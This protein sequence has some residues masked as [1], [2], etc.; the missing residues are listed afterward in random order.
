MGA[1]V[2]VRWMALDVGVWD[3]NTVHLTTEQDG[4]YGKLIRHYWR[5][6]P[7]PDD[8]ESLAAIAK[9]PL[10][11]W[12]KMRPKVA[13]YFFSQDGYLRHA[14]LEA[15]HD[16]AVRM[17]TASSSNGK[18]GGRPKKGEPKRKQRTHRPK[19]E[20]LNGGSVANV[21]EFRR[22]AEQAAEAA[23]DALASM[24]T[25]P[26]VASIATLRALMTGDNPCDWSE[27]ILPA[28]ASA[29]AWHREKGGPGS[30]TSWRTAA[31]IAVQ[32]RD[33]RLAG[34]TKTGTL[35]NGS[36]KSSDRDANYARAFG[37]DG[38]RPKLHG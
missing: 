33:Q 32:N 7:L 3:Q 20:P 18:K 36:A 38:Q 10:E 12:L 34:P 24:A 15:E 26:G 29:A 16:K 9:L 31:R 8:D 30:M 17:A 1:W 2:E 14:Y 35:T 5:E 19:T 28:I 37:S 23:G 21:E 4:A 6:G 11:R 27:D 13:G 25:H 22:Q